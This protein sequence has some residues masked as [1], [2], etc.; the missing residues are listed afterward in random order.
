MHQLGSIPSDSRDLH[1]TAVIRRKYVFI[2]A[3]SELAELSRVCGRYASHP[4][5][6]FTWRGAAV[7]CSESRKLAGAHD[8][9]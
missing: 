1:V 4:D 9:T 2:F 7:V 6:S 8:G 3:K 5:L